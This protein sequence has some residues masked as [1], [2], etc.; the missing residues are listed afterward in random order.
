[1][2]RLVK[3]CACLLCLSLLAGCGVK[4][5]AVPADDTLSVYATFYPFYALAQLLTEGVEDVQLN[6]LVQPQDD[7]LRD[8]QLSDWDLAL[9]SA[10]DAVIAGGCGLESFESLL[11]MLGE[12]GPMV[13][14][15]L[16]DMDLAQ[17]AAAN[18]QADSESHWLGENPHLYMSIDGAADIARRIAASLILLDPGQEA[19]FQANLEQTEA[20]LS[21]LQT[22]VDEILS[23]VRG[24]GVIVMNEAL[25]YAAQS[26]GVKIDLCYDRDSGEGL[27][28]TDLEECL[29][30]LGQSGARVIMIERQ[31]PQSLCEALEA[32]GYAV[33]PMDILS[34]RR[35]DEGSEAYF[36]AHR[37]NARILKK[38]FSEAGSPPEA[39][40]IQE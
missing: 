14:S 22:E 10:A 23:D 29:K 28:G 11:Y 37:E 24:E 39:S 30:L 4:K 6:C 3:Y 19:L 20:K 35:A 26:Y 9:V 33:A 18:T 27:S 17:L 38:A 15:V 7:C 8:Y 16:Y 12:S 21:Q 25:V 5:E 31:A 1:M 32:A 36:S 2:K 34:T 13:S 40:Q